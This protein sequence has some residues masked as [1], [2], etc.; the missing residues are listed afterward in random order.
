MY[1]HFILYNILGVKQ[2]S[3]PLYT[4]LHECTV[5]VKQKLLHNQPV[6][7]IN[8]VTNNAMDSHA[9]LMTEEYQKR[10]VTKPPE[11][12]FSK[13][14]TDSKNTSL[15]FGEL[16][17]LLPH[18]D[19]VEEVGGDLDV[20]GCHLVDALRDGDGG[21]GALAGAA[22]GVAARTA[23]GQFRRDRRRR[24]RRFA[25]EDR[26]TMKDLRL[27]SDRWKRRV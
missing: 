26:D 2:S 25:A 16:L 7:S 13:K 6:Q 5:W 8:A 23:R 1:I 12:S 17:G 21:A 11:Y 18:L 20:A 27:N 15:L 19:G 10:C 9:C 14:E 3:G 24:S 22:G 4:A